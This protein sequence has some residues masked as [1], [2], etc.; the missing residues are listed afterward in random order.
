[1][2]LTDSQPSLDI[3]KNEQINDKVLYINIRIHFIREHH[4]AMEVIARKVDTSI[5]VS[6]TMTKCLPLE[7]FN[8]HK[9]ILLYG[10]MFFGE[11]LKRDILEK[12]GST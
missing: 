7:A 9:Q 2:I 4:L 12:L 6:D 8:K 10:H 11:Q 5:N 1:M 3:L